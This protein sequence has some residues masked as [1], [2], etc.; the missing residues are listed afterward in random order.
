MPSAENQ[1]STALTAAATAGVGVGA[2]V[3]GCL[4]IG[5]AIFLVLYKRKHN[6]SDDER[7]LRGGNESM[8]GP[9]SIH[10]Q[11]TYGYSPSPVTPSYWGGEMDVTRDPEEME[12][13]VKR[14]PPIELEGNSMPDKKEYS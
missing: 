14:L 11:Y 5:L 12:S 8:K 4:V 9:D 10:A 2:A 13:E 1:E 7:K 3:G 6:I